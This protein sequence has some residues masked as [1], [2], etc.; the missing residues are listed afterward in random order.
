MDITDIMDVTDVKD[1]KIFWRKV[2]PLFSDKVNLQIKISLVKKGNALSDPE[3]SS[4]V[5]KVISDDR[6]IAETFNDFFVNIFPIP[7]ISP[8][9][10]RS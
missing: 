2:K 10:S 9:R 6:E 1:N 5:D 3:I 7:K 4:E 8:I